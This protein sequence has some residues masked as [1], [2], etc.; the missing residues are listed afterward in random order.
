MVCEGWHV[1]DACKLAGETNLPNHRDELT[2][3]FH[4]SPPSNLRER[5]SKIF[6]VTD[7]VSNAK[8][9]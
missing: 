6:N 8:V 1:K 9:L 4:R 7:S 5:D 3:Y 2:K